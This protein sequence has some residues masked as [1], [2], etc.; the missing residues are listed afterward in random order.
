MKIEIHLERTNPAAA[1]VHLDGVDITKHVLADGFGVT[2]A[3]PGDQACVAMKL[4]PSILEITELLPDGAEFIVQAQ[5]G[6][7]AL[8]RPD[9]D[10]PPAP[11]G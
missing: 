1:R 11:P 4:R 6:D 5:P 8:P 10:T 2:L 3:Q 7:T 9:G